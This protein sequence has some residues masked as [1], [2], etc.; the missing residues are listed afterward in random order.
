[1]R[2]SSVSVASLVKPCFPAAYGKGQVLLNSLGRTHKTPY[3]TSSKRAPLSA[4]SQ[5]SPYHSTVLVD[6]TTHPAVPA[7]QK[8]NSISYPRSASVNFSSTV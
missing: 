7:Q 5:H 1:M 8:S 2:L 3:G 6:R 4:L